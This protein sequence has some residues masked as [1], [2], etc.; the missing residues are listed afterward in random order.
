MELCIIAGLP[1]AGL[2]VVDLTHPTLAEGIGALL[3]SEPLAQNLSMR[4]AGEERT[5][6]SSS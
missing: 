4:S 5:K 6:K 2:H 3:L 1:Y